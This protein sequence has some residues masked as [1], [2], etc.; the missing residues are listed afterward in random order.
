MLTFSPWKTF[1]DFSLFHAV[2]Q[3]IIKQ[4]SLLSSICLLK[5]FKRY[6]E[7]GEWLWFS[8]IER[9]R[10]SP[11]MGRRDWLE[12][13]SSVGI[14][15]MASPAALLYFNVVCTPAHSGFIAPPFGDALHESPFSELDFERAAVEVK[16]T[17]DR[18]MMRADSLWR[19]VKEHARGISLFHKSTV[20]MRVCIRIDYC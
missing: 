11:C 8:A 17:T 13:K 9:S 1:Y 7:L 14:Y 16:P 3:Q 15:V 4:F 10:A 12:T 6:R 19:G 5:Q 2:A 18:I 20:T